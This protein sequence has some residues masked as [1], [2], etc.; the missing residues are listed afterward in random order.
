MDGV[1]EEHRVVYGKKWTPCTLRMASVRETKMAH[2][3]KSA[4]QNH[5][6]L[7]EPEFPAWRVFAWK[8]WTDWEI[9]TQPTVRQ[10]H[11]SPTICT[12][13]NKPKRSWVDSSNAVSVTQENPNKSTV[14][15]SKSAGA[16]S[17]F[18]SN[19]DETGHCSHIPV[20]LQTPAFKDFLAM[21][22]DLSSRLRHSDVWDEVLSYLLRTPRPT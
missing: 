5:V 19:L 4:Y 16:G 12:H 10:T 7:T 20:Y 18:N 15:T 6:S 11:K 17:N 1:E 2:E 21:V 14:S 13:L 22:L 8:E 9:K 3:C